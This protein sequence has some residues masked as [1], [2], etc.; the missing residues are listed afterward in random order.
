MQGVAPTQMG[1]GPA[2]GSESVREAAHAS[3]G[4]GRMSGCVGACHH[5]PAH[6]Q[7]GT[8]D[9]EAETGD[10]HYMRAG[11]VCCSWYIVKIVVYRLAQA[12]RASAAAGRARV[13]VSWC[14]TRNVG[15]R[16][17]KLHWH[18]DGQTFSW[19]GRFFLRGHRIPLGII[20]EVNRSDK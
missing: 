10:G 14:W 16:E 18:R 13:S 8:G 12:P 11:L 5:G 15:P 2:S 9:A 3:D 1:M 6:L 17:A 20:A 4:R 19:P 7:D